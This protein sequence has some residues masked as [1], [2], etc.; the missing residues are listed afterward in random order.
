M[1]LAKQL[2]P[3]S[4]RGGVDTK[5]DP[6]QVVPG[7]LLQLENA[8]FVSPGRLRKRNGFV[9]LSRDVTAPT[10]T[11]SSGKALATFQDELLL[12]AA[13]GLYSYDAGAPA[14]TRKGAFASCRVTQA[15]VVRDTYQQIAQDGATHQPTGV[16][17]YAWEDS[18]GGVYYTVLDG[19]TGQVI[20]PPTSVAA[21]GVKPR[22]LVWGN[23]FALLYYDTVATRLYAATLPVATPTATLSFAALTAALTDANSVSP[24]LPVYDALVTQTTVGEQLFLA[25]SNAAGST[26]VWRYLPADVATPASKL[27]PLA[28]SSNALGLF[29][30]PDYTQGVCVARWNGTSVLFAACDAFLSA[31]TSRTVET[32]ANVTAVAGAAVIESG[33]TPTYRVFYSVSGATPSVYKV[34]QNTVSS[35]LVVG[36]ASNFRL[37]VA[38]AAKPWVSG[39]KAYVP[40]VHDSTLQA[41]YFVIDSGGDIVAKA[42]P[43]TAGGLPSSASNRP[44]LPNPTPVSASAWRLPMLVKDELTSRGG[45][46]FTQT[47]VTSVMVDFHD[48][49]RGYSR[50]ELGHDLHFGGGFLAMYDGGSVVEHGFHL[51]PEGI[52]ASV[53]IAGTGALSAGQ[54]Q[55]VVCYEWMDAQGNLHRSAPSVPTTVTVANTG[56]C[57]LTI[58]CL[59][60]TAKRGARSPVQV[61]VYR[62]TVD[63]SVFYRVSSPTSPTQNGYG[64]A[65]VTFADTGTDDGIL[66]GNPQLYTTGDVL[67]N[68]APPAVD[69]LCVHANRVFALDS[70]EPLRVWYSKQVAPGA[71]AE[72]NDSL[73]LNID[74]RGGDVTALGSLD[75]KLVVFKSTSI[76]IVTGQGPDSTGAQSDFDTRFV[77]SDCGCTNPRSVVTTPTGLMF[78]SAKGI[79]LLGRDLSVT[80]IGAEVEAYNQD[81]VTAA[82]LIPTANQV[83]FALNSGVALVYDYLVGQWST[84]TNCA[85]VDAV[86]WQQAFTFLR[87]DG[88]TLQEASGTFSDAGSHIPLRLTTSWLQFANLTGFQR[89]YKALV[90]GEYQTPHKLRVGVAYDFDPNVVQTDTIEPQ[91]PG[92]YGSDSPYGAGTPYGGTFPLYLYRLFMARQ[93]CTAVQLTLEDVQS[94][95]PSEGLSLSA[96]S[97]EIGVKSGPVKLPATKSFG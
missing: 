10:G 84:F 17:C 87:A 65:T 6:K 37:S 30:D 82:A 50:A 5:S 60:L 41:T 67:E 1:A 70:A 23:V 57:T 39:A 47:G 16:Q 53:G 7:K 31:S 27:T 44:L 49:T 63:G 48:E 71:P 14:W 83:R 8:T 73:F 85:A 72:F 80:Y 33:T 81:T 55:Y 20:T 78:Q 62:T 25:F 79:Y 36:T 69:A 24:A 61:V 88:T 38:L 29:G 58:P 46:I 64:T 54:Y 52:T 34:R 4:L 75:D 68:I 76:F 56:S 11:V 89:V 18:R 45:G 21:N 91:A 66:V 51:F 77:T 22:V 3:I 42:L 40:V 9:A 13:T 43:G 86:I 35:A 28:G 90:L 93:K 12:A 19:T 59:Q 92:A 97:L 2:V 96:V 74:P 94:G 26:S 32:V 15:P 95:V